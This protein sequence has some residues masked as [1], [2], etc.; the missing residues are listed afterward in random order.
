MKIFYEIISNSFR[1]GQNF[2]RLNYQPNKNNIVKFTQFILKYFF[3]GFYFFLLFL[4]IKVNA[5]DDSSK[6]LIILLKPESSI[7]SFINAFNQ[8][9]PHKIKLSMKEKLSP[10]YQIYLLKADNCHLMISDLFY[11]I[12]QYPEVLLLQ[13]NRLLTLREKIPN[14]T[15][16]AKQWSL[17]NDGSQGGTY[18]ADINI[19]KAWGK[20]TGGFTA[21]GDTIVVAVVDDGIDFSHPDLKDNLWINYHEIADNNQDDDSNG[22]V[23]DYLGWN[24]YS[25]DDDIYY[26]A[27]HGTQVC[28]VLGA[29]GN[30]I[31]GISGVNWD[32]KIM[33]VVGGGYEADAIKA[34]SYILAMRKLYNHTNGRKGAYIVAT[35]TSWGVS[36]KWPKDAPVWC[37]LYDSMGIAGIVSVAATDNSNINVDTVGDLPTTCPS[38]YLITV[39]STDKNDQ[40]VIAAAYGKKYIDIGCP[41]KGILTT[42]RLNTSDGYNVNSG[43][44]FASPHAA[45]AIALL[46]A[47][48][49]SKLLDIGK[50]YPD[51]LA[52]LMKSFILQGVKPLGSLYNITVTNGRL[53]V[54]N[55][56]LKMENFCDLIGMTE[57]Y[58]YPKLR[59]FPTIATDYLT[60]ESD[61][62]KN[63]QLNISDI[64]GKSEFS[65]TCVKP[66]ETVDITALS[67]GIY[68]IQISQGDF[69]KTVKFI[70]I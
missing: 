55:A 67:P 12:Q 35:N 54:Y 13:E 15:S 50:N 25:Y 7:H 21:S 31:T 34:Y 16:F 11:T 59:V 52:F 69:R 64:F 58:T 20:T 61:F 41:G 39:T 66:T 27:Y 33:M 23:D 22:Y 28:G 56:M 60:I 68:L 14:D 40:K 9:N 57:N 38:K 53:D 65:L 62:T 36:H 26:D 37:A 70:K 51:S 43:T 32:V 46:Y 47:H 48:A 4:A 5:Q 45:G 2:H 49:C 19:I 63:F 10:E 17:Y 3:S 29:K 24:T 30:N 8:Q 1:Q 18:G 42:A 6:E 44:S